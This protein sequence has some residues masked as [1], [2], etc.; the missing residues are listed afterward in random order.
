MPATDFREASGAAGADYLL[1]ME[2][3]T[4][5]VQRNCVRCGYVWDGKAGLFYAQCP[6]CFKK[7]RQPALDA[8]K[9]ASE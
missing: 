8:L 4:G 5:K 2:R 6:R 3:L 9:E 1:Y 7:N